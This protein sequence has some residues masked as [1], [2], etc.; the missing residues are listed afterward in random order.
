[1]MRCTQ[2]GLPYH[3]KNILNFTAKI[4]NLLDQ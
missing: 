2:T 1:M 4:A 3:P